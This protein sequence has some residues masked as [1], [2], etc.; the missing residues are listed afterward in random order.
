M[1]TADLPTERHVWIDALRLFAGL[2]MVGLHAT[3]DAYG[4]PFPDYDATQ[5]IAPMLLR[6]VLYTARTELFLM[7]SIFLLLMSLDRKPRPYASVI[8]EQSRRL[9][10]PFLFW[11]VFY[12]FYGLIKA[13]ALGYLQAELA[14]LTSLSDWIAFLLLGQVKYHMHF[15]PT[16]FAL[17]L[18]YPMFLC[19]KRAPV[20]G[21]VVLICLLM[22]QHLD[23][24]IYANFWGTEALAYLVR[25]VKVLS[26]CGYG[27]AAGAVLGLWQRHRDDARDIWLPPLL[28]VAGLLFIFK[29]I[30]IE[31]V[32]VTGAW[33]FTYSPGYWADFL[34]PLLLLIICASLW[35][36]NWPQK[37]SDMAPYSFGIYLCHPIFLDLVEI[38]LAGRALAPMT[39]VL[40]EL[41]TVVPLTAMFVVAVSRMPAFAWSIGL[42][43]LP[44]TPHWQGTLLGR[45]SG[46]RLPQPKRNQK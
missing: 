35:Q 11:T 45:K 6:A 12:A 33:N 40:I 38:L 44:K 41:A 10:I 1:A 18:F 29:L 31:T 30:S 23:A 3:A 19:A 36:S 22:K 43:P 4:Q 14:R 8:G 42:G 7:I 28:L 24:Y 39:Q 15:I 17:V 21:G 13:N 2:S 26:Y 9:L 32:I 5:R 20:F 27:L 46:S 25:A 16:L 34:M 37:I